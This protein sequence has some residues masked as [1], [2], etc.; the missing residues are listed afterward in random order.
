MTA[1]VYV[2]KILYTT[3]LKVIYTK[4]EALGKCRVKCL[5]CAKELEEET[6]SLLTSTSKQSKY[7]FRHAASSSNSV[8]S[9]VHAETKRLSGSEWLHLPEALTGA[10]PPNTNY[11]H[12]MPQLKNNTPHCRCIRSMCELF[13]WNDQSLPWKSSTDSINTI[14][15]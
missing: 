12:P 2:I 3:I 14:N 6:D 8:A 9:V 15:Q 7:L 1:K 5:Y 10:L 11:M 4:S 13:K